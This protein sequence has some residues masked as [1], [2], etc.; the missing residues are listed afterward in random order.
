MKVQ[1][2]DSSTTIV[3]GRDIWDIVTVEVIVKTR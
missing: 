2:G 3:L 1:A